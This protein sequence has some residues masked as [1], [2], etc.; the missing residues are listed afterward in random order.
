MLCNQCDNPPCVKACPT[1]A[2][3]QR[4]DGIVTQND[5]ICIGCKYCVQ[6][7]PYAIK[8]ADEKTHTAHKCDFCLH[9]VEQGL[10]PAC[11][12]TCNARA[13]VFGDLNDPESAVSRLIASNPVQT[14][15]PEM[16]TDP[17][18]FYIGLDRSAYRLAKNRSAALKAEART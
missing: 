12:N 4:T 18:V 8:Y 7:C 5:K 6:A 16:G 9:R 2:T 13:R 15:R 1:H 14:L 3:K 17:R 10:L 11:V